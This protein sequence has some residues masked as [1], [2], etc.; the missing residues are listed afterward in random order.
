MSGS[1]HLEDLQE[2]IRELETDVRHLNNELR[3]TRNETGD[4]AKKYFDIHFKLDQKVKERTRELEK[5]NK[6]LKLEIKSRK[7]AEKEREK[8]ITELRKALAEIK[9]LRNIIPICS[10]CK[11]IR[12]DQGIWNQIEAYFNKHA[13]ARF[14]HGLCPDCI[15][16]LYPELDI[17]DADLIQK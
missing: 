10:K 17:D 8:L 14:T 2:R 3:L 9:T 13:D 15:H 5:S 12:D 6:N 4:A 1:K 11:K 7:K 16:K